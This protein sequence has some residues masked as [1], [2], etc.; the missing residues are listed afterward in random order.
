METSK[1][2]SLSSANA[3][4]CPECGHPEM[5]RA[6]ERQVFKY[7][8]GKAAK[9]ISA[10]IPMWVCKHCGFSYFDE[11]GEEAR[12]EA[13]CRHIGVLTPKEIVAIRERNGLTQVEL[14]ALTG[15]GEAS[16]KRWE[17]GVKIQN[18]SAD[19]LL[20]L[21]DDPDSREKLRQLAQPQ[22]VNS[23]IAFS[24]PV[25]PKFRTDLSDKSRSEAPFF[26]LC[27]T[28]AEAYA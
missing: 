19:R 14:A 23:N 12:H 18:T 27:R 9:E 13:V 16:I 26:R 1:I 5:R 21:V 20:R 17:N 10:N 2:V 28:R 15:H 24:R 11:E 25:E 7:G 6:I 3:R 8:E 22:V 4:E